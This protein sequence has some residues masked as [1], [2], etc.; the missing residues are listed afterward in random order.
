ML[1]KILSSIGIGSA[2]V[3]LV[4]PGARFR[5]GQTINGVLIVNGGTVEQAINKVI[6]Q[7]VVQSTYG[8]GDDKKHV[9]GVVDSA[10]IAGDFIVRPGDKDLEIPVKYTLPENIPVTTGPTKL[11][12]IT[13]MDISAAVDPKDRDPVEILPC[14][15]LETVMRALEKELGFHRQRGTGGFNG[16]WQ[17]FEYRP[18]NFMR[19]RL[20][21]LEVIY[22][23]EQN[24]IRL[25]MEIDK[26]ARG[27][28]GLFMESLDM[29]ERHVSVTIP[30]GSITD[31][32]SVSRLLAGFIQREYEK[33]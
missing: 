15:R 14:P 30:N 4:L 23:L 6:L 10:V 12:F 19:G 16:R 32:A 13:T 26:K 20:D 22:L 29:D 5:A 3:D 11:Y 8:D 31:P 25:I 17:K 21:E 2:T 33:I 18:S 9:T 7:L 27:L 1:K 24:G 28:G